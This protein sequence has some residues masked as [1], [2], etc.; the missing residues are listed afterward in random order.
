MNVVSDSEVATD[1]CISQEAWGLT[2]RRE[3]YQVFNNNV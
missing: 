3:G 1:L 2:R